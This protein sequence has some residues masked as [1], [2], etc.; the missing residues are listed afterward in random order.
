M[1]HCIQKI[2]LKLY[3]KNER[4]TVVWP[5]IL[6]LWVGPTNFSEQ[7]PTYPALRNVSVWPE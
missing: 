3:E 4:N 1:H 6:I 7:R 2:T 5:F